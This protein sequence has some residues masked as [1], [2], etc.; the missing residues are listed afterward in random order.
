MAK[1][2]LEEI[3]ESLYDYFSN[4]DSGGWVDLY[5]LCFDEEL[6]DEDIDYILK[7]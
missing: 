3:K 5:N 2:T 1:K 6:T 4:L 7:E